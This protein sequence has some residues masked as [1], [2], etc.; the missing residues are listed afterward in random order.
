MPSKHF[1]AEEP[2][3]SSLWKGQLNLADQQRKDYRITVIHFTIVTK[4]LVS[5]APP[6]FSYAPLTKRKETPNPSLQGE[7]H[8]LLVGAIGR[9][10]LVHTADGEENIGPSRAAS[11]VFHTVFHSSCEELVTTRGGVT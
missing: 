8:G 10:L 7:S 2:F 3:G 4:K 6:G 1:R 9:T 11:A 5:I